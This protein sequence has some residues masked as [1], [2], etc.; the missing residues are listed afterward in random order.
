[1]KNNVFPCNLSPGRDPRVSGGIVGTSLAGDTNVQTSN[2]L[3]VRGDPADERLI[4]EL[5]AG[6]T[7]RSGVQFSNSFHGP[8]STLAGVYTKTADIAFM[9][10]EIRE[11]MERM[12]FQWALLEPPFQ[13]SIA[14]AAIHHKSAAT[15]LGVFVHR[16]NPLTEISIQELDG[17]FGAEHLAGSANLRTWAQLGLADDWAQ[18][19]IT[20]V[21]SSVDSVAALFFRRFVMCDSRKWN[22]GLQQLAGEAASKFLGN[23]PA[24]IVIAPVYFATNDIRLVSVSPNASEPAVPL[25]PATVI[26]RSYPLVRERT[27]I[28]HRAKDAP[29]R[30]ELNRF[31][32]FILSSDGQAIVASSGI[33]LPLDSKF[34][35][36]EL[37][38]LQ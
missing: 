4:L 24:A 32:K 23:N 8:E 11:P 28:V 17:I 13:I 5:E 1:V 29:L 18:R 38:K 14:N 30:P 25:T 12:A 34:M 3:R 16:T 21:T 9:P 26:N 37:E 10:R 22:P 36:A 20:P 31:L 35:S 19:P 7:E 15:Q 2:I 27:V 6:F 33:A